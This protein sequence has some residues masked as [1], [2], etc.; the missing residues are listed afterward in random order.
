MAT[1]WL[2]SNRIG[3][4]GAKALAAGVAFSGS[5]ATLY[6]GGNTF[7]DAAKQSLRDAVRGRQ[8]FE[9]NSVAT[10]RTIA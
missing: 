8:G 7:G 2:S 6:I 1:L 4:E 5:M 10:P 9:M 3:D